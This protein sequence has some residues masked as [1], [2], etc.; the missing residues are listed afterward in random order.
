MERIGEF[1]KTIKNDAYLADYTSFGIGGKARKIA[2]PKTEEEI[3]ALLNYL[4]DRQ[5][6]Y[7]VLGKGTNVLVSDKGFDGVVIITSGLKEITYDG[8]IVRA[9]SGVTLPALSKFALFLSLSGLEFAVGIPAT[10]G[11]AIR[12]NAGAYGS[13]MSCVLQSCRVYQ[14]GN[15]SEIKAE[16]LGF[17]Y[18]KSLIPS[19][20]TVLSAEFLLTPSTAQNVEKKTTEFI[21]KRRS[22]QPKGKSAGC[23]FKANDGVGAGYYIDRAGLKGLCVGGAEVSKV[24]AGFIVNK[25]SATAQDVVQLIKKI[26][27][28]VFARFG[29]ELF[30]EINFLGEYDEDLRRLSHPYDI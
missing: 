25:G 18:R 14:K 19:L 13:D 20:G 10:V 6:R 29:V 8:K 5:I 1:C 21:E 22:S 7:A 12:M 26:Q 9:Q 23:I 16:N 27:D 2:F 24:H 3:L 4:E 28:K 15:I 11:G 30:V 17:G